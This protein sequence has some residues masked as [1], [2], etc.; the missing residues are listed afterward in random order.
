MIRSDICVS[1]GNIDFDRILNILDKVGMAEIRIDLLD[2]MPNQLEMVFSAH[3][4]LI[5]TCRPGRYDDAQRKSLLER[6]LNAGAAYVDLEIESD[7]E[8][9]ESLI[10]LAKQLNRKVIVSWH[11]FGKTPVEDKELFDI[12]DSLYNAGADIAKIACISN[13]KADCARMINLYSKYNNL[14]AI[15]MGKTGLISRIASISLGA[16]FTYA[17]LEGQETAPGQIDYIKMN[18]LINEIELLS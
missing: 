17:S 3:S 7:V 1:I 14:V 9:R 6:A 11:C 2:L 5:A 8:W 4:N 10:K 18:H 12:V 15:S 16:P 13:S